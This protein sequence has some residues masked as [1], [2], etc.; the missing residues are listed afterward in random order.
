MSIFKY[1]GKNI[2]WDGYFWCN[3]ED[4]PCNE[5]EFGCEE[6]IVRNICSANLEW[7]TKNLSYE[8]K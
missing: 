5:C 2:S 6:E 3:E 8:E 1:L 7:S 4:V